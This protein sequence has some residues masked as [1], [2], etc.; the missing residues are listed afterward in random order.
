M[1][2]KRQPARGRGKYSWVLEPRGLTCFASTESYQTV[3]ELWGAVELSA[4]HDGDLAQATQQ[5]NAILKGI[6]KNNKD[7]ERK[8]SFIRFQNRHMLVWAS[9]GAVGPDDDEATV[10]KALKLKLM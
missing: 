4:F 1:P 7:P 8:L 2:V 9:Y 5:I 10:A 3:S 6:E